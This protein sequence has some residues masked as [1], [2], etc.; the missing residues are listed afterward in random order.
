MNNNKGLTLVEI[1]A[2]ITILSIIIVSFLTFFIQSAR[3][4]TIS[5]DMMDA[6]YVAQSEMEYL[7]N[8]STK[9]SLDKA[10]LDLG[11]NYSYETVEG[12]YVV[13]SLPENDL[14]NVLVKVYEDPSQKKSLAQMETIYD[15]SDSN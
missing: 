2:S 9:K 12:Y 5:E 13:V 1:L 7:Y 6:T 3:T 11:S 15:W 4:N 14:G 10:I 8:L